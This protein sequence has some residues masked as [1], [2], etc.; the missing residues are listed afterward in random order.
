MTG[1]R[2]ACAA[3]FAIWAA[4]CTTDA[5]QEAPGDAAPDQNQV[6]LELTRDIEIFRSEGLEVMDIS[7]LAF[8]PDD[9]T[10][11]AIVDESRQRVALVDRSL[12]EII[13]STGSDVH[14]PMDVAFRNGVLLITHVEPEVLV[15]D[16]ET[17]QIQRTIPLGQA[18]LAARVHPT[19]AG[20][21]TEGTDTHDPRAALY[22]YWM[23]GVLLRSWHGFSESDVAPFW[24]GF[25]WEHAAARGHEVFVASAVRYPLV[26]YGA[27]GDSIE[28]GGPPPD[29]RAPRRPER[30]EFAGFGE[31]RVRYEEF[32]R[33]FT[34]ISSVWATGRYVVIEQRDLDPKE[35]GFRSPS[36]TLDVYDRATLKRVAARL[37]I[38]G[39]VLAVD[40][41]EVFALTSPA[42]CGAV[43]ALRLSDRDIIGA[44]SEWEISVARRLL[45]GNAGPD[46]CPRP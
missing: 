19:T 17:L 7:A 23:D 11:I 6:H 45:R 4:A 32:L 42:A 36:Y 35:M 15:T 21:I 2:P 34:M 3:I 22:E 41:D 31:P 18:L 28:F 25:F 37:P 26:R 8:D 43:D 1:A 27:D 38:D 9:S 10:R 12:G 5:R 39:P 46:L 16:P 40:E 30:G 44:S 24:G 14:R 29:Y 33:S 20:F 13:A